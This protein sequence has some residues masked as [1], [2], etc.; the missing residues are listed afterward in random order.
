MRPEAMDSETNADI[1]PH[2]IYV[3]NL[4]KT[5]NNKDSLTKITKQNKEMWEVSARE[6]SRGDLGETDSCFRT[7]WGWGLQ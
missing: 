2:Y 3:N 4:T 1:N 7:R 5:A 6:G